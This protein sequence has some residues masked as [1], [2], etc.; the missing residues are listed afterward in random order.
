MEFSNKNGTTYIHSCFYTCPVADFQMKDSQRF[1]DAKCQV[2]DTAEA[3][4]FQLKPCWS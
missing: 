3:V 2:D 4:S 1:I